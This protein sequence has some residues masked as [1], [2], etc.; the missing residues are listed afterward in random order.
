MRRNGWRSYGGHPLTTPDRKMHPEK[1]GTYEN[2]F[3]IL[4]ASD[5]NF[6]ETSRMVIRRREQLRELLTNY[7]TLLTVC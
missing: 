4:T 3:S 1:Y 7:D 5:P 2:N 6:E